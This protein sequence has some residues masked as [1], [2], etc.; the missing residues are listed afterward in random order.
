MR[1][2][3][4][5][6]LVAV[7]A[8]CGSTF[9]SG[10][11]TSGAVDPGRDG[12][13]SGSSTVDGAG[14]NGL[15]GSASTATTGGAAGSGGVGTGGLGGAAQTSSGVGG[16]AGGSPASGG[17]GGAGGA[18]A[19]TTCEIEDITC[20]VIPDGCG[21]TIDCGPHVK[22][23][24]CNYDPPTTSCQCPPDHPIAY[25]CGEKVWHE[26]PGP[27]GDCVPNEKTNIYGGGYLWCCIK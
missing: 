10:D 1:R 12:G 21:G 4:M 19:P 17:A 11:A 26:Q 6:L 13:T 8:A 18:C 24:L 25:G 9:D 3:L 20:G 7:L 15:G 27:A 23:P 2:L 16:A 22:V 14:G 5:L